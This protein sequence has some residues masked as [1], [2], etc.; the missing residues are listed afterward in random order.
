MSLKY[1]SINSL[2]HIT[3]VPHQCP[4]HLPPPP[5]PPGSHTAGP[6]SATVQSW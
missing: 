5:P 3:H 6:K 1:Y 2:V 4:A